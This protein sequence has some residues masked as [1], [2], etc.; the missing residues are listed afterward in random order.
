MH[1]LENGKDVDNAEAQHDEYAQHH[2]SHLIIEEA[3]L[4]TATQQSWSA[5]YRNSDACIFIMS[6][7]SFSLGKRVLIQMN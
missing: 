4:H 2:R 3:V 7:G 5:F 1:V 6:M